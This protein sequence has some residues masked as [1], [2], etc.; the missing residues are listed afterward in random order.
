MVQGKRSPKFE[1]LRLSVCLGDG[2]KIDE[3][4]DLHYLVNLFDI[5]TKSSD[6]LGLDK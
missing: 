4:A 6:V 3:R 1:I 2:E 5:G